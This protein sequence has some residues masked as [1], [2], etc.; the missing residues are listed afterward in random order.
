MLVHIMYTPLTLLVKNTVD[1]LFMIIRTHFQDT[2][3]DIHL[4]RFHSTLIHVTEPFAQL[5]S[6][7]LVQWF[8]CSYMHTD[9]SKCP[10]G[11]STCLKIGVD[12]MDGY[13]NCD[14]QETG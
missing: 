8:L 3:C 10:T 5:I 12:T 4:A 13:D 14:S 2:V 7:K 11:M 9:I 6:Q 1:I